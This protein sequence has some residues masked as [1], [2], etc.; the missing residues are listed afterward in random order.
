[1]KNAKTN[2]RSNTTTTNSFPQSK[3]KQK[4]NIGQQ[5]LDLFFKINQSQHLQSQQNDQIHKEE[6]KNATRDE[7]KIIKENPTATPFSSTSTL[8][9][10]TNNKDTESSI[11]ENN[12]LKTTVKKE[13]VA[14]TTNA[15]TSIDNVDINNLVSTMG[16]NSTE[17]T[18]LDSQ[19]SLKSQNNDNNNR[20]E[21]NIGMKI[22]NNTATTT[23]P[24][25]DSSMY[26]EQFHHMIDTVLDGESFLFTKEDLNRFDTFKQ[27]SLESQHLIV[28]LWMRKLQWI[29]LEK[30]DY[31]TTIRDISQAS[32][33]LKH[34]GLLY[35]EKE[36]DDGENDDEVNNNNSINNNNNHDSMVLTWDNMMTLINLDEIKDI[37]QIYHCEP[38][39]GKNVSKLYTPT[40]TYI[41]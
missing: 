13:S 17:S 32:K 30:L 22:D 18:S 11:S 3:K 8:D 5:K 40:Y 23:T 27:L 35:I 24:F 9:H 19:N 28:R 29:R 21:K 16:M 38:E 41:H 15:T 31:S 39:S 14:T 34:H 37:A 33:E 1:M 7:S 26:T 20:R 25:F 12:L 4:I 36:I 2:K 10:L 6:S